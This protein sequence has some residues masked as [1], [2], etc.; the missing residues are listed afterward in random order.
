M[1]SSPLGSNFSTLIYVS[2]KFS[3]FN[4][5]GVLQEEANVVIKLPRYFGENVIIRLS[6]Y[7]WAYRTVLLQVGGVNK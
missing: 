5:A 4:F 6:C 1:S 7:L 2:T 3:S